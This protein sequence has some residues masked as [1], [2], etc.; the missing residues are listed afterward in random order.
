MDVLVSYKP[1]GWEAVY[2]EFKSK[3]ALTCPHDADAVLFQFGRLV[4][5]HGW[6]Y[7]DKPMAQDVQWIRGTGPAARLY[8]SRLLDKQTIETMPFQWTVR[9]DAVNP[10]GYKPVYDYNVDLSA[11]RRFMSDRGR[12]E[13]LK[14]RFEQIIG[15]VMGDNPTQAQDVYLL[16]QNAGKASR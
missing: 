2:P 9:R 16:N 1:L 6:E 10:G 5:I 7:A 14:V 4:S 11:F 12:A 3:P 15:P 8:M 13:R